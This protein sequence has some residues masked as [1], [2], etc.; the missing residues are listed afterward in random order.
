MITRADLDKTSYMSAYHA[1]ETLRPSWLWRR[2]NATI[3]N[4]DPFP[5]VYLD[6]MR[7]GDLDELHMIPSDDVDTITRLS[8]ADATTRWGTGHLAGA[9]DVRTRRG[10]GTVRRPGSVNG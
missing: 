6:G 10:R 1:I 4:P 3:S 7:R 8:P 9:I 5:I 2:G